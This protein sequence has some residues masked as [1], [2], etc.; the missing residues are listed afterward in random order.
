MNWLPWVITDTT[1]AVNWLAFGIISGSVLLLAAVIFWWDEI[2]HVLSGRD[3]R[4]SKMTTYN[5]RY[6]AVLGELLHRPWWKKLLSIVVPHWRFDYVAREA[7]MQ[8]D[9]MSHSDTVQEDA[10]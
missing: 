10:K 2:C 9:S 6:L 1:S 3:R 4:G 5:E 8:A 7:R